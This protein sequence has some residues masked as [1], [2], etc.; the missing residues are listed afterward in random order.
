MKK[1]VAVILA[2]VLSAA[3]FAGCAKEPDRQDNQ[4]AFS[5]IDLVKDGKTEYAIVLPAD[6]GQNEQ[7][8]AEELR[9]FFETATGITLPIR[10]EKA[11]DKAGDPV[12]A[13]GDTAIKTALG[14]DTSSLGKHGFTLKRSDK[15]VVIAGQ[16]GV[17][18]AYGVYEFLKRQFNYRYY[19][20]DEIAID[21][22]SDC[23]LIDVNFSDAPYIEDYWVGYKSISSFYNS[24]MRY[25]AAKD[26]Q[27]DRWPHSHFSF[28]PPSV[29]GDREGWY[30]GDK[31]ALCLTNPEVM[32]EM[33][34]VVIRYAEENPETDNIMLGQEDS[35]ASCSCERCN[36]SNVK[37]TKTGTDL[38]FAN[39]VADK[40]TE[41]FAPI[42]RTVNVYT[43][44]YFNT[45]KPPVV[46][47]E[48]TGKYEPIDEKVIP[49]KNVYVHICYV[50]TDHSAAPKDAKRNS[51]QI[52]NLDGWKALTDNLT[53]YTYNGWF[54][55][56]GLV[57]FDDFA[58]KSDY[59]RTYGE[60]GYKFIHMEAT[61]TRAATFEPMRAYVSAKLFWNPDLDV[62]ALTTDFIDNYYKAAAPYVQEYYDK[63]SLHMSEM[64]AMYEAE[65]KNFGAFVQFEQNKYLRTARTWPQRVLEQYLELFEKA[66]DAIE[67]AGYETTEYEKLTYRLRIE[68]LSPRYLR[69]FLYKTSFT[70]SEYDRLVAEFNEDSAA[71]GSTV[72]I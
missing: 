31:K 70:T 47:N 2:A 17:G 32:E 8:A 5:Q 40:L 43:L 53:A 63:I 50:Y 58:Y 51:A 35:W 24:E 57:F 64:K 38:I 1:I 67:A 56:S 29:Y 14:V 21:K 18:T 59:I 42:G 3:T 55:N 71:L 4:N 6:P 62:N 34:K 33:A 65:N 48:Q 46:M 39:Y 27:I 12:F 10:S 7:T 69:L 19:A 49:H 20:G 28:L 54:I 9:T 72:R 16:D 36:E 30:S 37:Y 66:Y 45:E 26:L 52:L 23:K 44:N 41:R 61:N 11:G 60:Y 15:T 25:R 22:V 68:E 13:L